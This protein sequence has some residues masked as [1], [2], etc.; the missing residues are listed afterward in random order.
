MIYLIQDRKRWCYISKYIV[1]V[2]VCCVCVCARARVRVC[3]CARMHAH[4]VVPV[5]I[6]SIDQFMCC[7][8]KI[9]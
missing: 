8:L 4:Y 1:C 2:C 5:Y 7:G 9:T 3:V 6:S